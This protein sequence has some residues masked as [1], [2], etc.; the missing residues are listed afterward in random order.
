MAQIFIACVKQDAPFAD[1]LGKMLSRYRGGT[2]GF[3]TVDPEREGTVTDLVY[4]G[5]RESEACIFIVG[6]NAKL[7][8]DYFRI[9]EFARGVALERGNLNFVVP[10][11]HTGVPPP[12]PLVDVQFVSFMGD[13]PGKLDLGG[14][15]D[16]I[17]KA[18]HVEINSGDYHFMGIGARG[19]LVDKLQ[20]SLKSLGY[21]AVADG[22]FGP[23]TA[24]IVKMF[25]RDHKLDVTGDVDSVTWEKIQQLRSSAQSSRTSARTEDEVVSRPPAYWFLKLNYKR[26]SEGPFTVGTEAYFHTHNQGEAPRPEYDLFGEARPGDLVIGYDFHSFKA[27]VCVFIV[28][29]E[30]HFDKSRGEVIN[31]KIEKILTPRIPV[32]S[33]ES[34]IGFRK[35]LDE[36]SD[37]RLFSIT[38]ETFNAIVGSK[39]SES[40]QARI[41]SR[42]LARSRFTIRDGVEPVLGVKSVAA[43]I[44]E[45]IRNLKTDDV[46]KMIGV[47]G[48]WG[49]GKT[50]MVEQIWKVLQG[51]AESQSEFIR[52]NFHAWKYQDTSASWAYLYEAFAKKYF[53]KEGN[54]FVRGFT[55]AGKRLDLNI[56][57][58]GAWPFL[59][60]L[61][62]VVFFGVSLFY[63][64]NEV[65]KTVWFVLTAVGAV[66]G[67]RLGAK[68]LE[69]Y[70]LN[71]KATE[72]FHKY[73]NK[74]SF[75]DMLGI[76][77]EIQS[78]LR[79]LLECWLPLDKDGN[80]QKRII[81]FVD[82]IDRCSEERIVQLIDA[83]RVML[84]DEEISKRVI[85]IAAIDERMLKRAIK[86]KY[87]ELLEA[88]KI[89]D[90][91]VKQWQATTLQITSEY[92]DKLFLS[93]IKLGTLTST[94]RVDVYKQFSQGKVSEESKSNEGESKTDARTMQKSGETNVD[95]KQVVSNVEAISQS[96]DVI[97]TLLNPFG[98]TKKDSGPEKKSTVTVAEKAVETN[99]ELSAEE[100]KF[101]IQLIIELADATPRQ[102]RIFYYRYMLARNLLTAAL[103]ETGSE[104][105][106]GTDERNQL[107]AQLLMHYTSLR[108]NQ[109]LMDDRKA[110]LNKQAPG[111]STVNNLIGGRDDMLVAEVMEVLEMVIAY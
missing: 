5:I 28:T 72:V 96:R 101:L 100:H 111:V 48:N 102:I 31:L 70:R 24:A 44:A 75:K 57:K 68:Y 79:H 67:I 36:A 94:E 73:F 109:E 35:E 42:F 22:I 85:V 88:D 103:V 87:R 10:M 19:E 64:I 60:F 16:R 20:H 34:Q 37:L 63:A 77:S 71:E 25:Q 15:I 18:A 4:N 39:L 74:P 104:S 51:P 21:N 58:H 43:E 47:F 32:S 40:E 8:S 61:F 59:R 45:L 7:N 29:Q 99:F 69:K 106:Y 80:P 81:L 110:L 26:W 1:Q 108:S 56:A 91:D 9:M 89:V 97:S 30:K 50:F 107:M 2:I 33:F 41:V 105:K 93:G 46:G 84:E 53:T 38:A 23:Q 55:D 76:Q 11:L 14:L 78:E 13:D 3:Y 49:R 66:D 65:E 90:N 27:A 83:L 6:V 95:I 62:T 12:P 86:W 92:M 54:W 82:D 17:N 52:V 98:Q